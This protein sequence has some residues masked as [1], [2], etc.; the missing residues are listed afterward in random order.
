MIKN[1]KIA[2]IGDKDSILAFK[3]I[4]AEVFSVTTSFEANDLLKKLSKEDYA[5]IYI[6]EDIAQTIEDTLKKLKTRAY[7]SVIPI[8]T[9]NGTNGFCM[10]GL[11][12]DVEKA[13]GADIL[14]N[15]EDI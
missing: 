11:K 3:A 10:R 6:T 8:P 15:N 1:G 5:V 9:Q 7:P 14:F 4:G 2:V 12:K 13:I